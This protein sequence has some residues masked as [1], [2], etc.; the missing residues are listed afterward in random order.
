MESYK[1]KYLKYKKKYLDL[2]AQIGGFTYIA[3]IDLARV[4]LRKSM[5]K[6]LKENHPE[7]DLNNFKMSNTME[8]GSLTRMESQKSLSDLEFSELLKSKPVNV[9]S[10]MLHVKNQETGEIEALPFYEIVDGRH[11][12]T[13]AIIRGLTKINA[14][15]TA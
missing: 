6:Y 14:S 7:I 11:R 4:L 12:V 8:V 9:K 10:V 1:E 15:V 5:V 2:K 3:E 13:S